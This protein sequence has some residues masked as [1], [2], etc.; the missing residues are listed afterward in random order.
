MFEMQRVDAP[1]EKVVAISIDIDGNDGYK[2]NTMRTSS[3]R[4]KPNS[5]TNRIPK[6]MSFGRKELLTKKYSEGFGGTKGLKNSHAKTDRPFSPKCGIHVVM[7]SR[8]A[9]AERS[10]L[11]HEARVRQIVN[12]QA[13]TFHVTVRRYQNVGNHL[14]MII[15]TK[16]RDDFHNFLRSVA[17]L[18]A[19]HLSGVE[20]GPDHAPR[21]IVESGRAGMQ[22]TWGTRVGP[23]NRETAKTWKSG[24]KEKSAGTRGDLEKRNGHIRKIKRSSLRATL[25]LAEKLNLSSKDQ[26]ATP[27]FWD[28]RPYTRLIHWGKDW[29][30]MKT[31]IA[32]NSF[33]AMGFATTTAKAFVKVGL[34]PVNPAVESG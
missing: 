10:M 6:Q 17:N 24:E 3:K 1:A 26:R 19:R 30:N 4:G 16:Q 33:E 7:K 25:P 29:E 5:I 18:L 22:R 8:F 20:R 23:E 21:L 31:Y 27:R 11:K 28:Q 32:K 34:R 2:G 9:K 13:K 14:H 12:K 15:Q